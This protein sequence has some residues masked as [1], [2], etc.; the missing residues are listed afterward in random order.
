MEKVGVLASQIENSSRLQHVLLLQ[1][2]FSN[3]SSWNTHHYTTI[4]STFS[5][6]RSI[7][8]D[9]L[10]HQMENIDMRAD[11]VPMEMHEP[12][13][14]ES[15]PEPMDWEPISYPTIWNNQA[16]TWSPSMGNRNA[17]SQWTWMSSSRSSSS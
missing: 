10:C 12:M 14:W 1:T 17:P 11:L 5:T 2:R 16:Q 13:D 8:I 3:M 4:F 6:Q 15:T 9:E 7:S